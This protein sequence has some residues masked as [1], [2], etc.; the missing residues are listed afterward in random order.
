[1]D[2]V[3]PLHAFEQIKLLADS[4]RMRILRLLMAAPATLSQ[5]ADVLCQSPVSW[6]I[7]PKGTEGTDPLLKQ[8]APLAMHQTT[9]VWRLTRS[10]VSSRGGCSQTPSADSADTSQPQHT[11]G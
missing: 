5:L 1:M 9:V 7:A 8:I 11:A 3:Q 6:V 10:E 4:R 2:K